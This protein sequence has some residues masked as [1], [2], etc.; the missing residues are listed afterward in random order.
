MK[1]VSISAMSLLALFILLTLAAC[2]PSLRT[3]EKIT[4]APGKAGNYFNIEGAESHGDSLSL[5]VRNA[6]LVSRLELK[7]FIFTAN[8]Y[9]VKG[10]E[11][12]ICFY[13]NTGQP[14]TT[15]GYKV[16][17]NNSDYR[18][19]NPQKTG[20]LALIRNN[21]VRTAADGEWF[22]LTIK[23]QANHIS[24]RVNDRLISEYIQPAHPGNQAGIKNQLLSEGSLVLRKTSSEG[25]IIIG[26]MTLEALAPDMPPQPDTSFLNDSTDRMLTL[27]NQQG[28]PLIDFHAH[29]KGGL[30]VDQVTAHGRI[31]GYNYGLAPN[32]GL[33][34]PVTN[35]SSLLAWYNEMKDEPVFKAMQCEGREWVTLFSPQAIAQ[36][37]YIF[38]DAMTW[39][40][41]RG[42][43]M[44]LW[45]PEETYVENE[46]Q[47]MDMLVRK[48]EAVLSA[49]PVDLYVN[50]TYLPEVI[51]HKYNELWTNERM[52]RVIKVLVEN[53]VALE[54]NSRFSIPGLAFVKKAKAAGVKFTLGTNNADNT[55]LGRLDYSLWIIREAGITA[56]DMFIPRPAGDRKVL[57][58]G[59]P[60]RITG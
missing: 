53:D 10:A 25:A 32:C 26:E 21:F 59:L 42:R 41:H 45:I 22:T 47:F 5:K 11:G 58:K 46:Q 44:R 56:A 24:V 50:P 43:R 12:L 23:V 18:S 17:I 35:D 48:I 60:A 33:N 31:N 40:D 9:T 39:T 8:L 19:G 34:F 16:V 37:D 57:K 30:T 13:P 2:R 7:N 6:S 49:E 20:S 27:L 29:L 55:D 51:A 1:K 52:D 38:T 54:I 14:D 36:Y 4:I 3:G 28:F 15:Q